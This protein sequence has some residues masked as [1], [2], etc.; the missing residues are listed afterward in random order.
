MEKCDICGRELPKAHHSYGYILCHKHYSQYAKYK[1]FKDNNPLT[2]NDPNIIR[3][4][5]DYAIVE[6]RNK[7]QE[8]IADCIIDIE[9]VERIKPFKWRLSK[10]AHEELRQSLVVTGN[11]TTNKTIAIYR[12]IMNAPD[13]IQVDH[14]DNDRLNNRKSNLRLCTNQENQINVPKQKNNS[15]GF[16]GVWFDKS[17][18]KWV[19]EIRHNKIKVQLGR[20]SNYNE[21]CWCRYIAES[22]IQGEFQNFKSKEEINNISTENI[23]IELLTLRVQEKLKQKSLI[24]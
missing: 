17:R 12:L 1:Q 15:S 20:F 22:L 8:Y 5:E 24:Q 19:A 2:T 13:G 14:I 9:D 23:D 11:S 4:Y 6:I 21:A 7:Q 16:K 3:I 18:E 10:K